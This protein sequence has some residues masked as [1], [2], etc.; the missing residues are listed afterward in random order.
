M[1]QVRPEA[2]E[3]SPPVQ[4]RPVNRTLVVWGIAAVVYIAI[5]VFFTDFMLSLVIAIGYLLL[6]AWLIPAGLSRLFQ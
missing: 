6:A 1:H 4:L 2:G 5:S 3:R